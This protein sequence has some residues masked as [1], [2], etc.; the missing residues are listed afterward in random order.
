MLYYGIYILLQIIKNPRADY[1]MG[2]SFLRGEVKVMKKT[3]I[4]AHR[5]AESDYWEGYAERLESEMDEWVKY[6]IGL[7]QIAAVFPSMTEYQGDCNKLLN[8]WEKSLHRA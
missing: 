6:F 3:V 5:R 8:E 2:I 4:I 1:G 7:G